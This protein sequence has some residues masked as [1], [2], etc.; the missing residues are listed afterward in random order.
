MM[1]N[2]ESEISRFRRGMI[3]KVKGL[4]LKVK[5]KIKL[6]YFKDIRKAYIFQR[7]GP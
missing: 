1:R 4:N 7:R 2:L 5:L 3:L 6:K